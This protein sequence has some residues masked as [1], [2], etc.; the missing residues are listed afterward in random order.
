M[1]PIIGAAIRCMT[2]AP[3]PVLNRM[4]INPASIARGA[5]DILSEIDPARHLGLIDDALDQNDAQ[6]AA[7]EARL[8][9]KLIAK[10]K[11]WVTADDVREKWPPYADL[12]PRTSS[13][14]AATL[15]GTSPILTLT[16]CQYVTF[17]GFVGATGAACDELPRRCTVCWRTTF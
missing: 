16:G 4:G 5:R 1:P 3:V 6:H 17:D 15:T 9:A 7:L 11:G 8:V 10:K 13:S 14:I 2:S 12:D